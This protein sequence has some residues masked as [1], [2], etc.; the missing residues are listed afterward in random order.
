MRPTRS[1]RTTAASIPTDIMLAQYSV[2]FNLAI[3][4]YYDPRDP[5]V[6][7]DRTAAEPR[8]RDLARR[9]QRER[10]GRP[11]GL[12]RARHRHAA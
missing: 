10:G 11:Q 6:Y 3:A 7:N 12:E 2:P 1:Y 5:S 4:A 9:V 8:L